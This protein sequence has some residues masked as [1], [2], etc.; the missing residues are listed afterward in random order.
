MNILSVQAKR[1]THFLIVKHKYKGKNEA[2]RLN[3]LELI[4]LFH[5]KLMLFE[6]AVINTFESEIAI[7]I[8]DTGLSLK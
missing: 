6:H 1:N 7:A 2:Q 3:R 4:E 8:Y 5:D